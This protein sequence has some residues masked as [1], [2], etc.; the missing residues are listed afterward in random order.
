MYSL[1]LL[2]GLLG[3]EALT[4]HQYNETNTK[5]P[6]DYT[7]GFTNATTKPSVG[8]AATCVEG[9]IPVTASAMNTLLNYPNPLNQSMI[10]ETIVEYLQVNATLPMTVLGAKTNVSGTWDI[11]AKLCF[12]ANSTPSSKVQFLTHGVGFDGSYWDFYSEDYSYQNAAALKGYTT[13]SY[14]RL[15]TGSSA[16][17]DPIQTV[18]TPLELAIAHSLTQSLRLGAIASTSFTKVIGVGHS[19]G[20][21]LTSAVT[22]TTPSTSTPP[23]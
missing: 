15:G 1:L 21:A 11:N 12:P 14:D 5:S 13:F 20:S 7:S 9:I 8:G 6:V 23:S 2:S 3:A 4:L 22:P 18:Q 10:T 19:L 16:H 17:P